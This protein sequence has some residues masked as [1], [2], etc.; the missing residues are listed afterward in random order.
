MQIQ[1]SSR[2][3]IALCSCFVVKGT[4]GP[5]G[6]TCLLF[7]I[8]VGRQYQ[9]FQWQIK[10]Q[11]PIPGPGIGYQVSVKKQR[12]TPGKQ[13]VLSASHSH[14]LPPLKTPVPRISSR[15]PSNSTATSRYLLRAPSH[16]PHHF[17]RCGRGHLRPSKFSAPQK[18]GLDTHKATKLGLKC[19]A[20]SVQFTY[21]LASLYHINYDIAITKCAPEKI[22]LNSH[23]QDQ[24][25][26]TAIIP[27]GPH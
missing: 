15:P 6:P 9:L 7:H 16:P 14:M 21:K 5:F 11:G 12:G 2:S 25:R 24:A 17:V 23:H 20:H 1:Q 27:P 26:G 19:H 4:Y 3:P 18:L 13:G 22:P 8:D 10:F